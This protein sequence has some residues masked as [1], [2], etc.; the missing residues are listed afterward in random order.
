MRFFPPLC[1]IEINSTYLREW[2]WNGSRVGPTYLEPE[3]TSLEQTALGDS[4]CGLVKQ[5]V[6][7]GTNQPASMRR[8]YALSALLF[9]TKGVSKK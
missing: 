4:F 8:A 1:H 5:L 6:R 7:P 3:L 9:A 2:L